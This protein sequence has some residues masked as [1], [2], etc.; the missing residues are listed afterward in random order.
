MSRAGGQGNCFGDGNINHASHAA[1]P[2]R[3]ALERSPR[4]RPE[5]E[6]DYLAGPC[7]AARG[8][9]AIQK[10]LPARQADDKLPQLVGEGRTPQYFDAPSFHRPSLTFIDAAYSPIR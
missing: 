8:S 2:R 5:G 3:S 6:D 10:C 4:T 7:T 1:L 9:H